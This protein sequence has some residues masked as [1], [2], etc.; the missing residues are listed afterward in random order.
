MPEIFTGLGEISAWFI[1][2]GWYPRDFF[3]A[4]YYPVFPWFSAYL[5]G[6][7]LG[8]WFDRR[9]LWSHIARITWGQNSFFCIL[10]KHSLV[11]YMLHVPVIYGILYFFL[12]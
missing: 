9:G 5:L 11:F 1:P 2:L 3:S 12:T 10:G 4:D 8:Y 7:T 6:I